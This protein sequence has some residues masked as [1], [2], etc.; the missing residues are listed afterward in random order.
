VT[1]E[2]KGDNVQV[3]KSYAEA[4]S[5]KYPEQVVIAIAKDADGKYNPITLGWTMITSGEPPMMAISIGLSRHSLGAVRLSREFVIS[6]PSEGMEDDTLFFGSRSGR[7]MDKLV[8]HGTATEPATKIDCVLLSDAVANFECVLEAEV[9]SGDHAV[10]VG[11]VV[12]SHVSED[13]DV[14]RLYNFGSGVFGGA[15]PDAK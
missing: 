3:L 10:F 13:P 12:A 11:R 1:G 4:V 6:F 2:G 8:A 7:D 5:R 14:G 15:V 9:V